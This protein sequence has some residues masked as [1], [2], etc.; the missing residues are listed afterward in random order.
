MELTIFNKL[1]TQTR[2]GRIGERTVNMNLKTGCISFSSL[3]SKELSLKVGS[4]LVLAKA[5]DKSWYLGLVNED[6]DSAFSLGK[7][8]N[9]LLFRSIGLVRKVLEEFK[10]QKTIKFLIAK[11]G[12]EVDKTMWYQIIP[13]K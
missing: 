1:N 11:E 2:S 9:A 13:F 3:A 5:K 6:N 12:K 7:N 8:S 4:K 10:K